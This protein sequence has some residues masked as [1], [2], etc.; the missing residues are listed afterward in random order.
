MLR[1]PQVSRYSCASSPCLGPTGG[2]RAVFLTIKACIRHVPTGRRAQAS[3]QSLTTWDLPSGL[4][5][6]T[7]S[8]P[9][10][11]A[12]LAVSRSPAGV[13][14]TLRAAGLDPDRLARFLGQ[15]ALHVDVVFDLTAPFPFRQLAKPSGT[16]G[17]VLRGPDLRPCRDT[18]RRRDREVCH[19][20]NLVKHGS[21]CQRTSGDAAPLHETAATRRCRRR[22]WLFLAVAVVS[23]VQASR[24]MT[25][26]S[27]SPRLTAATASLMSSRG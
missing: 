18:T 24:T 5:N 7:P 12:R 9:P 21:P 16:S 4:L 1:H 8:R 11:N 13:N 6:D 26:R 25:L 23:G 2:S 17:P 14:G 27:A 19:D 3:P 20:T 22:A 10:V 15:A